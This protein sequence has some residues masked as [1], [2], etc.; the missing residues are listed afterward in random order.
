MKKLL[1]I[2]LLLSSMALA[3][4]MQQTEAPP[5]SSSAPASGAAAQQTA[6]ADP[7][8]AKARAAVDLMVKTL[9]GQ[10]YL[11]FQTKTE[12]GRTYSFYQ[13]QPRG[14]GTLYWRFW[15][16]PD[17]DRTEVTKQRDIAYLVVGD[18][19]YEI[20]FKGTALQ[21]ADVLADFLR[22]RNHSLEVVLREWMKDPKT[23]VLPAGSGVAEQK[24]CDLVTIVNGQ[25]DSV[26]IAIDQ[27]THLPV[28]KTFTYRDKDKYKVEESEVFANY[29]EQQG[30]M[31]PFTWTRKKDGLMASQRFITK[32]D[33]NVPIEDAKFDAKVSYDP[34]E[35]QKEKKK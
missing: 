32:I 21:E 35:L 9:G 25:N 20:T 26:T 30:I 24:L 12:E 22:R 13:G 4:Q 23:V 14:A 33:Y 8:A 31:T 2:P 18:S 16:Y 29:R 34:H 6:P 28:Q 19:G 5:Q 15:K 7:F 10:G 1:T 3:Q 27:L 11:S 17:K